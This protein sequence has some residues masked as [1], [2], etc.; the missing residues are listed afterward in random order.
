MSENVLGWI[1][2]VAVAQG[3][4]LVVALASLDVRN[5]RA[6]WLLAFILFMLTLTLGEEFLDVIDVQLG[7]GIGLVAEVLFWPLLFLFIGALAED[8]PRPLRTQWPHAIPFLIAV[9]WYLYL[10]ATTDDHWISLSNPDVRHQIAGTVLAKS[11]YFCVYAV[12]ILSRPLELSAKPAASRAALRWVRRWMWVVCGAYALGTLSFLAFYLEIDWAPD[13]DYIGGL[14]MVVAI[15]S[16]GYFALANRNVFDVRPRQRPEA[17]RAGEAGDL[18][19]RA[20]EHLVDTRAYREPEL[21]LRALADALEIGETRLSEALNRAVEGGFYTL[22]NDLRLD[23]CLALLDD[24]SNDGR[25]VLELAY[26]AGFS[27]KATFYRY[28]K[29]RKGITPSA[30]REKA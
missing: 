25:T 1:F 24:P 8:D 11:L 17:G 21:G 7:F 20:R 12:M 29:A 28:F 9:V 15:Y 26:E 13:S 5:S 22:I 30:Y 2:G 6:R 14:I 4:A 19:T 18:V 3:A 27:S 10:Y 23:E 16:L